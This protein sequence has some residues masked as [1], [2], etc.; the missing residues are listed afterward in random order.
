M[1]VAAVTKE[2]HK[3]IEAHGG[4]PIVL[5]VFKVRFSTVY[6]VGGDLVDLSP[7]FKKVYS[8][9]ASCTEDVPGYS[10]T[11]DDT[12]FGSPSLIRVQA[13]CPRYVTTLSATLAEVAAGT[14]LSAV[15]AR[16]TVWGE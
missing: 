12:N 13:F 3:K 2:L 1:G 8:I 11:A 10:F 9:E 16:L 14:D 4:A 7:Y 15:F 5:G 6:S